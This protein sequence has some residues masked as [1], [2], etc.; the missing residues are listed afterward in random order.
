MLLSFADFIDLSRGYHH[1]S[2]IIKM[3]S[4]YLISCKM[5]TNRS[6]INEKEVSFFKNLS[7]GWWKEDSGLQLLHE[8]NRM[9]GAFVQDELFRTGLKTQ[10]A[11]GGG[12][13]KILEV[14]CGGG[15]LTEILARMD[16]EVTAIDVAPE[17]VE[18]AKNH[19]SSDPVTSKTTYIAQ[20][21]EDH[22]K[23]NADKYDIVISNFVLEHV[24]DKEY[25]LESCTKCVKRGGLFIVSAISKT[26]WSWL[27]INL[28]ERVCGYVPSGT[29][30]W[31]MCIT[32]QDTHKMIRKNNFEIIET[33]GYFHNILTGKLS[34]W[35]EWS[36]A[37][38]IEA[39]KLY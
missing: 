1:G 22:T 26:I 28:H 11:P 35:S 23:H 24:D 13:V 36:L 5:S 33:R 6:T 19:A 7:E 34:W 39:K 10:D 20:S 31:N 9:M 12:Q 18:I 16:C 29:H 17:L 2:A 25:F 27:M 32:A 15:F 21:I 3:H 30:D 8:T 38:V 4:T 14:G 37:Y